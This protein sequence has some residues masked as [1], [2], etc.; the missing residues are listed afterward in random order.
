M[1]RWNFFFRFQFRRLSYSK[2]VLCLGF[3]LVKKWWENKFDLLKTKFLNEF[4]AKNP[5]KIPKKIN[6][7]KLTFLYFFFAL[8]Y[9]N[10]IYKFLY[11][12]VAIIRSTLHSILNKLIY[13]PESL[14]TPFSMCVHIII[15]F[16][17]HSIATFCRRKNAA[18]T[19]ATTTTE[20]IFKFINVMINNDHLWSCPDRK[21]DR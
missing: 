13:F 11:V 7:K 10:D 16:S 8:S 19:K 4:Y 1:S 3:V 5:L 17:F 21:N 9:Q 15:I 2:C 14:H 6:R 20:N 12:F 18:A